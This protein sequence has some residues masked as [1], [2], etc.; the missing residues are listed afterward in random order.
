MLVALPRMLGGFQR[1]GDALHGSTPLIR[2]SISGRLLLL[3]LGASYALLPLGDMR[4]FGIKKA[5]RLVVQSVFAVRYNSS[6]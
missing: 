2:V 6:P 5:K 4:V 3:P 1:R